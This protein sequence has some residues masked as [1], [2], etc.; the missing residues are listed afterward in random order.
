MINFEY[1]NFYILVPSTIFFY[2]LFQGDFSINI[3]NFLHS[4]PWIGT[5]LK[6]LG[7]VLL[8]CLVLYLS[9]KEVYAM[10][11]ESYGGSD[12]PKPEVKVTT[13]DVSNSVTIK[14]SIINIP[15]VVAT[16]LTNLGTGAAV[17]AGIKAG[18][19]IVKASG[20]SPTAKLGAVVVSGLSA[21]AIVVGTN[22]ANSIF[23]KKVDSAAVN[24]AQSNTTT[25]TSPFTPNTG[26][27]SSG[28]GSAAFSIEPSAD[29]DTVMAL[30]NSDFILQFCILYLGWALLVIY[31]ANRVVENKWD[32]TFIKNIFG[33][34]VHSFVIKSLTYTSKSNNIWLMVIFILLFISTLASLYFSYFILNNIDII[35][36]I[37]QQSKGK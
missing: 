34:K 36:E 16:G 4:Y 22:A 8:I 5:A 3:K 33:V 9:S 31:I 35:S 14:D 19:S 17:A 37:V 13:G 12:L 21:G 23:Q 20:I 15:N 11:P 27:G 2:C 30:L 10:A 24:Y 6:L 18:A 7:W 29:I 28:N 1:L 32:L 25:P 26:G